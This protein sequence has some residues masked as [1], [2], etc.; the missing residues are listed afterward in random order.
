MAVLCPHAEA[1]T[2]DPI[3]PPP[4]RYAERLTYDPQTD[5][6]VVTGRPV[7]GTE[8]GDLDIA[9]QWMAREDYET[10]LR[11]VKAWIKTYGTGASRYP[12]A[13]YL[14]ATAALGKGDYRLANET[15]Q[16]LLNEYPGSEF[17][18]RALSAQ[19]RIAEQYLAGKKRKAFWGL[20]RVRDREQGV[21]IMDDI[22][23]NYAD[24]PLAELAQ[25]AKADYYYARG[26][27]EL[28]ETEYATLAREFPRGRYHAYALLQSARSALARYPGVDFDDASLLEAEERFQQ[29]Q[30]QYPALARQHNVPVV[31]EEIYAA[32]AD[33][34]YAIAEHYRKYRR[35]D[36]ARYYY[37]ATLT[38]FPGTAAAAQAE[39]R[40]AAL[41]IAPYEEMEVQPTTAPEGGG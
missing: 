26:D 38:R 3:P 28:A 32:R 9:R 30:A 35:P 29:F 37:R 13:L 21:K 24:T 31:L 7:P 41:G 1:Q 10:A 11:A 20:L 36:A 12:E 39:L 2:S 15:Y 4:T 17:S 23:A 40:L 16:Q 19:F 22:V 6:W 25:K 14:Q 5:Q 34:V 27:F 8:D 33:K 18:E